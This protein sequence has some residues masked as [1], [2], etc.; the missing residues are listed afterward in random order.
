MIRKSQSEDMAYILALWM[1]S[2]IYDH[3]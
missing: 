1:K 2:T 3:P